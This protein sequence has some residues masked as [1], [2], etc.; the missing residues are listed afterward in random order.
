MDLRTVLRWKDARD[1]AL[2]ALRVPAAQP[3][4]RP[5]PSSPPPAPVPDT[6]SPASM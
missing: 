1:A 6:T 2:E 4:L 5:V 3:A